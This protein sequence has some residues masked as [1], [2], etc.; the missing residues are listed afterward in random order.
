MK[1]TVSRILSLALILL[2]AVSVFPLAVAA[3]YELWDGSPKTV[4]MK[5]GEELFF[6]YVPAADGPYTIS[7]ST[8]VIQVSFEQAG[9]IDKDAEPIPVH[10]EG[11]NNPNDECYRLKG[12]VTYT[13]RMSMSSMHTE[14]P[15]GLE[16]TISI[17][18]GE[19]KKEVDV[20]E[21]IALGSHKLTVKPGDEFKYKFTPSESG[22]YVLYS[23][24]TVVDVRVRKG[25]DDFSTPEYQLSIANPFGTMFGYKVP[26]TAGE[27][28]VIT[29][30]IW[31]GSPDKEGFTDTYHLEKAEPLKSVE[32][33]SAHDKDATD[34]YGY[35]GG[36][37][38]LFVKADPLYY[39]DSVT[40]W[41]VSDPD[42]ASFL[43]DDSGQIL[44][45]KAGTVTATAT[46]EGK[47]YQTTVTVKDRPVLEENKTT[48]LTFGGSLGAECTFTPTESGTYS[49]SMTGAGG[50]TQIRETGHATYWE[51]SG[52]LRASLTAGK[53]Y[54]LVGAFGP[55]KYTIKVVRGG[56]VTATNPPLPS[57]D[58]PTDTTKTPDTTKPTATEITPSTT[59]PSGILAT[60]AVAPVLPNALPVLPEEDGKGYLPHEEVVQTLEEGNTVNVVA[61]SEEMTA[62]VIDAESLTAVAQADGTLQVQL[63]DATIALD[64]KALAQVA[65]QLTGD[66]LELTA[67]AIDDNNLNDLQREALKAEKSVT[68]VRLM[69]TDGDTEI[70]DFGGG[71][72]T[73]TFAVTPKKGTSLKDYDV[74]YL[75]KDGTLTK[76]NTTVKDGVLTF[77]TDH[78]SEYV[79]LYRPAEKTDK[80]VSVGKIALFSSIAFLLI[81]GGSVAIFFIF[82]R[83]DK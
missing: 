35:V 20:L 75:A 1:K 43:S 27:T 67:A 81:L 61:N 8:S 22:T 39:S 73:V 24:N 54:T 16:D 14:W 45:N 65:E 42:V 62:L 52:V 64:A 33:R 7:R 31:E 57:G 12:G 37:I 60:Q 15:D 58:E 77:E 38:H 44:L 78:F 53:T 10:V 21:P 9:D 25:P 34:L 32:L 79:A 28:Y 6:T 55:S 68:A 41:S 19:P 17:Y 76:M 59:K 4:K 50:T 66:T 69:L 74:F 72:V 18:A 63:A 29:F 47:D 5:A 49:F 80:P 13:V 48:T 82:K 2:L 36:D 23:Q 71:T 56:S 83:V 26:M 11:K 46:V 3:E 51:G 70:H 40:G 30:S